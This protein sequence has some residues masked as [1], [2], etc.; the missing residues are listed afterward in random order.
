MSLRNRLL[1][2][3]LVVLSLPIGMQAQEAQHCSDE[4]LHG[5]YG[6][7]ATGTGFVAVQLKPDAAR[8]I[9]ALDRGSS[10]CRK[11]TKTRTCGR[12]AWI[13]WKLTGKQ[14]GSWREKA[15]GEGA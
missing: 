4:T 10:M 9:T 5:R 15:G 12:A 14:P 13:T 11:R 2:L 3:T 8:S 1:Q 6:F 7:H